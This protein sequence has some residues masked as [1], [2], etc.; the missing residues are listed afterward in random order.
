MDVIGNTPDRQ[1]CHPILAGDSA[2]IGMQPIAHLVPNPGSTA[3][4]EDDVQQTAKIAVRHKTQPSLTGLLFVWNATQHWIRR[5]TASNHA[6][7]LSNVPAGLYHSFQHGSKCTN[8]RPRPYGLNCSAPFDKL[9]AGSAALDPWC[10]PLLAHLQSNPGKGLSFYCER[11]H[12]LFSI[13]IIEAYT[14]V[15]EVNCAN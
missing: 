3:G 9:R 11:C 4:R 14:D 6:G 7:L 1:S 2:E 10:P 8:S 12:S 13:G 15:V 5:L